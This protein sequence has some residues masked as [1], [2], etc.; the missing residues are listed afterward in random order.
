MWHCLDVEVPTEEIRRAAGIVFPLFDGKQAGPEFVLA[1][2]G[3]DSVSNA[4]SRLVLVMRPDIEELSLLEVALFKDPQIERLFGDSKTGTVWV[5]DSSGSSSM[6][7]STLV[8][9]VILTARVNM[10]YSRLPDDVETFSATCIKAFEEVAKALKGEKILVVDVVGFCGIEIPDGVELQTAWGVVRG[11]PKVPL[12]MQDMR[13]GAGI[14]Q[15]SAFLFV[16]RFSEAGFRTNEVSG[17]T[18]FDFTGHVKLLRASQ[19]FQVACAF[20][21]ARDEPFAPFVT[22]STTFGPW[23]GHG[24]FR[25]PVTSSVPRSLRSAEPIAT[26]IE[27]W[28]EILDEFH[29]SS[30]DVAARRMISAVSSR[31]DMSDSLIDAVIVWESLVGVTPETTFRVTGALAKLLKTDVSERLDFVKNLK[32]IYDVRSKVGRVQGVSATLW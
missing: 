10:F 18:L 3:I 16:E 17:E 31:V 8:W 1:S 14:R 5:H 19:L 27:D 22:W 32:I 23:F 12:R 20:A 26:D 15:T 2:F 28:T 24:S 9:N 21:S 4:A 25:W 30:L 11:S 7:L 6:S 29:P 13:L